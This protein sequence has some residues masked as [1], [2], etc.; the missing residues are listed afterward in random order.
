MTSVASIR[1]DIIDNHYNYSPEQIEQ[2]ELLKR[3]KLMELELYRQQQRQQETENIEQIDENLKRLL[4]EKK[5]H[6][7]HKQ[8]KQQ[9][10]KHKQTNKNKHKAYKNSYSR[11]LINSSVLFIVYLIL[12][13]DNIRR[14]FSKFITSLQPDTNGKIKFKGIIS[15]GIILVLFYNCIIYSI[16]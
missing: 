1:P 12:S 9:K 5:K 6:K 16:K 2:L 10:Q 11:T 15:Y 3:Q 8:K 4:D 13:Q 7:K 14:F